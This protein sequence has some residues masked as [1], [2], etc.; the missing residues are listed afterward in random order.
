MEEDRIQE[1]VVRSQNKKIEVRIKKK[2]LSII[3]NTRYDFI[4]A[5]VY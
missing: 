5:S 3:S 4:L 2:N 1:P